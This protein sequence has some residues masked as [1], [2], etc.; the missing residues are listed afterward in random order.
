MS[1]APAP[2]PLPDGVATPVAPVRPGATRRRWILIGYVALAVSVGL[3][4]LGNY[5][6][7][8][9]WE[10]DRLPVVAAGQSWSGLGVTVR[11]DEVTT[12]TSFTV[13]DRETVQATPGATFVAVVLDYTLSDA[14][15]D[16]RCG[17]ELLGEGRKWTSATSTMRMIDDV[18]PGVRIGCSNT[19]DAG[20]PVTS[21]RFGMLFE[22]PTS[23]L[24]EIIG[25]RM[26]VFQATTS[27][28]GV[29][30]SFDGTM[31][32]AVLQVAIPS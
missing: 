23:A 17:M 8:V 20:T 18:V 5:R 13:P 12:M 26:M 21:G 14:S 4:L 9:Y 6:L 1:Y 19:D 22:V 28:G 31:P 11:V 32:Q 29:L 7:G 30:G 2:P 25:V 10:T 27:M 24:G 16:V 3:W 15:T